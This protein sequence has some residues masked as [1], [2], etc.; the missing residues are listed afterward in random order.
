[1]DSHTNTL[2]SHALDVVAQPLQ[3]ITGEPVPWSD[4]PG[5][6]LSV[7]GGLMSCPSQLNSAT[8]VCRNWNHAIPSGNRGIG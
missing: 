3:S 6:V 5:D 8:R 7:I 4:L 2:S 1:M